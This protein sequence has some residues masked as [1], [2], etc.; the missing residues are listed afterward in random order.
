MYQEQL[1]TTED[2]CKILKVK[3]SFIRDLRHQRRIP[4]KKIGRLVRYVPAEIEGWLKSEA[5]CCTRFGGPT[6]SL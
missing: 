4:F 6:E 1:W 3:N 2:L 5:C